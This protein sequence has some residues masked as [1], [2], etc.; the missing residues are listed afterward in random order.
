[1]PEIPPGVGEQT[2]TDLHRLPELAPFVDHVMQAAVEVLDFLEVIY[3]GIEI[4]GCWANINAVRGSHS[5]HTHP[6]N[7]LSGVYCVQADPGADTFT[8]KDSRSQRSMIRARVKQSTV[9]NAGEHKLTVQPGDMIL[10]P[11]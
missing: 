6:N 8:I 7:Y 5:E 4:T 11:A 9:H 10:F 3:D 1:M 2:D